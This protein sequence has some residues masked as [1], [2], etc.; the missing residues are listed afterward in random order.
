MRLHDIN[1]TLFH[2]ILSIMK[3]IFISLALLA[4]VA[5]VGCNK[6]LEGPVVPEGRS[7]RVSINLKGANVGATKANG[8]PVAAD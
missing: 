7:A 1:L 4:G 6:N 8:L 2:F 3:K 5:L